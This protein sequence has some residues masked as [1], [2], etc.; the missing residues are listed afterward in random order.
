MHSQLAAEIIPREVFTDHQTIRFAPKKSHG[1]FKTAYSSYY[2]V[3]SLFRVRKKRFSYLVLK[4]KYSQKNTYISLSLM[5]KQAL[6]MG[7][8]K[9][10][11]P[12]LSKVGAE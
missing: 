10:A 4:L 6:D 5:T 11:A 8:K 7:K 9:G 1:C 3:S 12:S 2:I